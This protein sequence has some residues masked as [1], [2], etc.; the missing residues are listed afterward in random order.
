[1]LYLL[2]IILPEN[3]VLSNISMWLINITICSQILR[4]K[5]NPRMGSMTALKINHP[6][7]LDT[8][9]PRLY[10]YEK[11]SDLPSQIPQYPNE[12]F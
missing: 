10:R 6:L 4:K 1:M 7:V 3:R 2:N 9:I 5:K 11:L 8:D 12:L